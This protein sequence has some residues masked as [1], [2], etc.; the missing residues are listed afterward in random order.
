MMW[1]MKWR[2]ENNLDGKMEHLMYKNC[3]PLLFR[4]RREARF[5]I[6]DK[7]GFLKNRPDLK[8]E[9]HGWKMPIPVKVEIKEI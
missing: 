6:A 2:S 8:K 4:T 9:P 3:F 1:G 5:F 7:W